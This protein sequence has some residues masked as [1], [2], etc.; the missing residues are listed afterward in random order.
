[1]LREEILY[2][3]GLGVPPKKGPQKTGFGFPSGDTLF[4]GFPL[5]F[6]KSVHC[7]KES[8][9]SKEKISPPGDK[10]TP[11]VWGPNPPKAP[12]KNPSPFPGEF[13]KLPLPKP[14]AQLCY[15]KLKRMPKLPFHFLPLS[16][17]RK[18]KF[19]IIHSGQDP[20]N[21]SPAPKR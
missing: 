13:P 5:G 20:F 7:G 4:P 12:P 17:Y 18:A 15:G 11:A 6:T 16:P 8:L 1:M 21:N 10:F 14:E 2:K 19:G 9:F 3:T